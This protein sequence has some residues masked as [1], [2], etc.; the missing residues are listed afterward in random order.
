MDKPS[1]RMKFETQFRVWFHYYI[2]DILQL[3][4]IAMG[5][6]SISLWNPLQWTLRESGCGGLENLFWPQ[7]VFVAV[8]MT[9]RSH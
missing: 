5:G 7:K 8:H 1:R 3:Y 4:L 9:I 6:W 2:V